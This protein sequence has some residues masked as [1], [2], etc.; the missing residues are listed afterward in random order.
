MELWKWID[1]YEGK[2]DINPKGEVRSYLPD[3]HCRK[4]KQSISGH[5]YLYVS[6]SKKTFSLHR[7]VA[8]AFVANPLHRKEVNH[9]DGNKKNPSAENLEWVTRSENIRHAISLGL[10]TPP[11]ARGEAAN[12]SHLK[13]E[14][15]L[16]I[17]AKYAKGGS[18]HKSLA[19][20]Y[21][22]DPYCIY[23]IVNRKTWTH[24]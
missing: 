12:K 14:D 9:R 24:I 13:N 2:Y 23:A 21:G 8:N 17:R 1:G 22:V 5:G 3:G 19:Q 20:Q 7:L 11:K 16:A 15:V 10:F 4:V 6:L 18:T